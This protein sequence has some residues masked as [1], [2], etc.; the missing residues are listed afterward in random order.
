MSNR[1]PSVLALGLSAWLLSGCAG[2]ASPGVGLTVGDEKISASRIDAATANVCDAFSD[3]LEADGEIV[4]LRLVKERVVQ[5]LALRSASEQIADEYDISPSPEY[6]Q[7]VTGYKKGAAEMPEEIRADFIEFVSAQDLQN[8]VIN[9]VGRLMLAADEI[10]DPTVE[11]V[12]EAGQDVFVTWRDANGIEVNP[13]Y[14]V[15]LA[16]DGLLVPAD[17]SLSFAVSDVAKAGMSAE[18][19]PAYAASLPRNQRCGA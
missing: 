7:Q 10:E 13:K 5:L 4:P 19:D 15:E 6:E 3:Q 9:Q 12:I 8:D 14:G 1:L 2:S 17:T 16:D 18:E 11:Q